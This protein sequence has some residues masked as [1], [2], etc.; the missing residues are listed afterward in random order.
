MNII[1]AIEYLKLNPKNKVIISKYEYS[2]DKGDIYIEDI[3]Y[4]LGE[5]PD[6]KQLFKVKQVPIE[7]IL[8]NSWEIIDA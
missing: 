3:N 4:R 5:N 2:T 7:H 1:E 6:K 8:S